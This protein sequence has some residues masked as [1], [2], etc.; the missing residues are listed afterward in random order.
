MFFAR[1]ERAALII[2]MIIFAIVGLFQLWRALIQ[3]PVIVGDLPVPP[4]LSIVVGIIT[5]GMAAWLGTVLKR[6]RST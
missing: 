1:G 6:H 5:L 2:A 4:W 3:L